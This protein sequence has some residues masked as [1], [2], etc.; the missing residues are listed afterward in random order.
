[1]SYE[2]SIESKPNSKTTTDWNSKTSSAVAAIV[3]NCLDIEPEQ[4]IPTVNLAN[5][6]GMDSLSWQELL[7]GVKLAKILL[8]KVIRESFKHNL[9]QVISTKTL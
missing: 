7:I 3:S 1:M 5:D 6:L 8:A 9:W 4:V 2:N